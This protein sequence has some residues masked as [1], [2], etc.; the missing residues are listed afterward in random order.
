VANYG[1]LS[2]LSINFGSTGWIS[3]SRNSANQWIY[4]PTGSSS[5][6]QATLPISVQ[7]TDTSGVTLTLTNVITSFGGTFVSS[8]QYPVPAGTLGEHVA[9]SPSSQTE[10]G[11]IV[12]IVV[13][14]LLLI[15]IVVVLR[16]KSRK[17]ALSHYDQDG[18]PITG[19]AIQLEPTSSQPNLT[20]WEQRA[21]PSTG[22]T[23]HY[24]KA[25]GVSQYE[26]PEGVNPEPEAPE[27]VKADVPLTEAPLAVNPE[28]PEEVTASS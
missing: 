10:I 24:N 25:S 17:R 2:A 7:L 23:Y 9:D 15:L 28:A 1:D 26:S 22:Q 13:I 5:S 16:Y 3:L 8:S 11:I 12:A 6:P 18:V 14:A 4:Q 27:G 20:D 19:Q 21:D